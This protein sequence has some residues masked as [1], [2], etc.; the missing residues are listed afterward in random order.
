MNPELFAAF[1]A[2]TAVLI[3]IPG[4]NVL[5]IVSQ[6]MRFGA[7]AGLMTVAGTSFALSQQLAVTAFGLTSAMAVLAGGFEVL[8]WLGVAYLLYLGIQAFRERPVDLAEAEAHAAATGRG[9]RWFWQAFFVTWT[10]PKLLAFY[11]AFFP[12]FIDPAL[13]AP[14]QLAAMCGAFLLIQAGLD[15]GYALLAT[16]L[17]R[18]LADKRGAR[19]RNRITGSFLV[20][21]ALGLALARRN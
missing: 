12:Q 2:A 10:N 14:P 19:L 13:P 3:L 15:C 8:R 7:R 6:S 21:A 1:A 4:P 5:L 16:R 9:R 18:R 11:V 17:R 20:A